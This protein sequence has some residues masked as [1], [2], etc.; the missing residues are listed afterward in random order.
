MNQTNNKIQVQTNAKCDAKPVI[1]KVT[2]YNQLLYLTLKIA[3]P[4]V[5]QKRI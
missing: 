4:Q 2:S 3:S 5:M 1:Y